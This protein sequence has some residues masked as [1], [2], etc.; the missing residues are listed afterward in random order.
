MKLMQI[1]RRKICFFLEKNRNDSFSLKSELNYPFPAFFIPELLN[2]FIVR[3]KE[4]LRIN[5]W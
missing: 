2:D 4:M 3:R 5:L 1:L